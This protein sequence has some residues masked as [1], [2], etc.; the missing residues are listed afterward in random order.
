[1]RFLS[2]FTPIRPLVTLLL[3][4][5][6]LA[7]NPPLAAADLVTGR[8]RDEQGGAVFN[9]DF[10]VYDPVTFEK[11]PP[12]DKTDA[13]GKYR[14][15]VNP[16]RYD[17]LCR[18]VIGSGLAPRVV[19]S[20]L[21]SGTLALDYTLPPAAVVRGRVTD[22][23][24]NGVY[25][26]DINFDR[27][28]DGERQP[29]LGDKTSPFGTFVA[30][31]EG[32]SYSV[33]ATPDTA[34]GLAPGRI[35]RWDVPTTDIL[36]IPL[37]RAVFLIGNIRDT[38]GAPVAGATF[39]F[40]DAAGFRQ[41]CTKHVTDANG[42][43][44]VGIAPGIYRVTV[45]PAP[46]ARL[47][48]IR[49]PGVD[50]TQN[51]SQDFTLDFGVA[52]SGTVT[53]KLGRPVAGANWLAAIEGGAVAVTPND[54]PDADG[55]YRFVVAP[56]LYKLRL[57]PPASSG[58]DSVVFNNVALARDTTINVDYAAIA[59]GSAGSS[60]V[61]RFA[62][63]GNPTHTTAALSLVL[64]KP[65]A[66]ALIEL[67]DVSGRRVSV[68]HAGPLALGSHALPWDGRHENGARAHT[69][70]YLVRARLDG[71]EQVTRFVL[72]P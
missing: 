35:Q 30:Y 47:A 8:V 31:V 60:P 17:I 1:M 25:P 56:G 55:H 32:G 43:F 6:A 68:L 53:D 50:L 57:T 59:G 36:S 39:R 58:L 21:V 49:V 10:N 62:P 66:A 16:G 65:I 34:T 27:F 7:A 26:S 29:A 44:R 63:R 42:F 15:L 70:V 4:Y 48:A 40:D 45:V 38:N 18:P 3:A 54:K 11:L 41:P 69:G 2:A 51:H 24:G 72:L 46:G 64:S 23:D 14:L 37:Q 67:F 5:A 19:R 33:T 13:T 28:D 12:S 52:V 22:P 20:V 61:V 9:A 71:L